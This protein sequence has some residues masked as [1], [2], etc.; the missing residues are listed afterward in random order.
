MPTYRVETEVS[1]DGSVTVKGLPFKAGHKV[2]VIVRDRNR[3]KEGEGP[4]PL[5][6]KPIRYVDPFGSV[7]EDEWDV[8]R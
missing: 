2:E 7:A 3:Q 4:Y 5:R 1:K 8:L 6:G